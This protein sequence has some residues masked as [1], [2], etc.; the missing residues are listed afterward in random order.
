MYA[1]QSGV[2]GF[3]PGHGST[4]EPMGSPGTEHT[5][6]AWGIQSVNSLNAGAFNTNSNIDFYSCNA[7]TPNSSGVSLASALSLKLGSN[8]TVSGYFGRTDYSGIYDNIGIM[9]KLGKQLNGGLY[10]AS[11]LPSAGNKSSGTG[12]GISEQQ[13]FKSGV[14]V[15]P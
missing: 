6:W 12:T 14:Q 3:E 5:K 8:T 7:A 9:G 13:F 11:N 1:T 4:G 15:S 10:P 2:G